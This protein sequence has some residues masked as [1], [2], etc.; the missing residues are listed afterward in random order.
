M[1]ITAII[2]SSSLIRLPA[3]WKRPAEFYC[4]SPRPEA[5]VPPPAA[6]DREPRGVKKTGWLKSFVSSNHS[7]ELSTEP[8]F[9]HRS[10]HS[11]SVFVKS[12]ENCLN[13]SYIYLN[14]YL[15]EVLT[16]GHL[17]KFFFVVVVLGLV[18]GG[19]S[20]VLKSEDGVGE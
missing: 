16:L 1:F 2:P 18:P 11:S 8:P 7:L 14:R 13:K 5:V 4:E 12:S 3:W 15:V 10:H 20:M 17:E 9:T 6:V 19:D